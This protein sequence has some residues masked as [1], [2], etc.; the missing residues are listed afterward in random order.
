MPASKAWVARAASRLEEELGTAR[1]IR[2][3]KDLQRIPG[4]NKSVE[5]SIVRLINELKGRGT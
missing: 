5:G 3:L 2:L 4:G 1:A